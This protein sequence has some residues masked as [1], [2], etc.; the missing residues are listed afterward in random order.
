MNKDKQKAVFC[1]LGSHSGDYEGA[2]SWSVIS[3]SIVQVYSRFE[4]NIAYIFQI[5]EKTMKANIKKQTVL[6]LP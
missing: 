4:G 1:I 3:L 2:V 5:E 6:S